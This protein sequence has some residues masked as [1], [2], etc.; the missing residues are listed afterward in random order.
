MEAFNQSMMLLIILNAVKLSLSRGR[1]KKPV[2]AQQ[3]NS[4]KPGLSLLPHGDQEL[5]KLIVL[6]FQLGMA[7]PSFQPGD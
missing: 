3:H 1:G 4:T 5:A 2:P 7:V 6:F